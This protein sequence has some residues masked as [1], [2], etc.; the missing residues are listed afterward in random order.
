[1]GVVNWCGE[2]SV[3]VSNNLQEYSFLSKKVQNFE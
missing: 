1:M 2:G 3:G